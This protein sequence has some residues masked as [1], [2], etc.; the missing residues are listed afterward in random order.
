M[1]EFIESV[2]LRFG[3]APERLQNL[4]D[5][6]IDY[7][8]GSNA[9]IERLTGYVTNGMADLAS[10]AVISQELPHQHELVHLLVN[11]ALGELPLG[12]LPFMQEGL[13]SHLGGRW[14]RSPAVMHYVGQVNLK[15]GLVAL[16]DILTFDDFHNTVGSPDIS[17][18]V[19]AVFVD[20]LMRLLKPDDFLK[21]YRSFSS[22]LDILRALTRNDIQSAIAEASGRP[23]ADL[24]KGFDGFWPRFAAVGINTASLSLPQDSAIFNKRDSILTAIWDIGSRYLVQVGLRS[25]DSGVILLLKKA[26]EATDTAYQSRLFAEHLPGHAYAGY[27][28]GIR[29]TPAEI[30]LYDYWQNILVASFVFGFAADS[31]VAEVLP[32]GAL[33]FYLEQTVLGADRIQNF[34]IKVVEY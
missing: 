25:M 11:Y 9:D 21:L 34:E 18:P 32:S 2:G 28:Y 27:H 19:S 23:W 12:T 4:A 13:A 17:Y 20:F 22:P 14:G 26:G 5:S 10:D 16:V 1:D 29:C 6:K 3:L 31:T 15:F 33:S 30:G 24:Q 8:L 7:Y